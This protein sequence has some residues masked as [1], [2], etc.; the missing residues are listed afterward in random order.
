MR[1]PEHQLADQFTGCSI[2][3]R[4]AISAWSAP[5]FEDT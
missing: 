4:A 5:G 3:H 1:N 2:D